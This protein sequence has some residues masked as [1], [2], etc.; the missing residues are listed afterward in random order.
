MT[1]R[2]RKRVSAHLRN[3][4]VLRP[5]D[6][7][8]AGGLGIRV[9][10]D[11]TT[12]TFRDWSAENLRQVVR[13][14]LF[15]ESPSLVMPCAAF[16]QE[17]GVEKRPGTRQGYIKRLRYLGRFISAY[18]ASYG[19]R[20][21]EYTHFSTRFMAEFLRWL[22]G[23]GDVRPPVNNDGGLTKLSAAAVYKLARD[24]ILWIC[25]NEHYAELGPS[26]ISFDLKPSDKG[27]KNVKSRSALSEA[28]LTVIRRA[29]FSELAIT[30]EKLN[31]GRSILADKTVKIPDLAAPPKDFE[32]FEVCLKAYHSVQHLKLSTKAFASHCPGLKR[33]LRP[34]YNLL[35]D[36]LEHIHFTPRSII[37]VMILLAMHFGFEPET[38]L[39]LN[40]SQEKDSQLYG[41]ARGVVTG[42]K[43]RGG[44][45]EKSK[46][47]AR[48][49]KRDY[50]PAALF[51]ILRRISA[52]TAVLVAP[53]C[54]KIFCFSRRTGTFGFFRDCSGFDKP[55]RRFIKQHRLPHFTLS[56]FR[57]TGGSLVGK[58]TG[59]DVAAQKA[60][61]QHETVNTTLISY[62]DEGNEARRGDTFAVVLNIRGRRLTNGGKFDTR[63]GAL[64]IE[65]KLAATMGFLCLDPHDSPKNGQTP[66]QLCQA[67]AGCPDC[68]LGA[69]DPHDAHDC[70]R[71]QQLRLRLIEARSTVD[72]SRWRDHWQP[73]LEALDNDWLP[74]FTTET[75][76]VASSMVLP[77]IPE[78]D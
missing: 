40:W 17:R 8:N 55:L 9:D 49:D 28:D 22:K 68:A 70:C 23:D 63:G 44:L 10:G 29:C 61:Q 53:S 77:P 69:I 74:A 37:P 72:P 12:I 71:L 33:A 48:T 62:Q 27:Y 41:A 25:D 67:Y 11:D 18:G 54:K 50:S 7:T 75:K 46:S 47:Y 78:V 5:F 24:L 73:K 20:I 31:L 6:D 32:S 59:G 36:V 66:G 39:G 43:Y 15:R 60:H 45:R 3:P 2:K 42:K 4:E 21:T 65:K 58:L 52:E 16:L 35:G 30:I 19:I 64:P 56:S 13:M 34:P 26:D 14:E 38:F 57:K 51:N 76:K 1:T